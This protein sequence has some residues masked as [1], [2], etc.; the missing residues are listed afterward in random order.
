MTNY[1]EKVNSCLSSNHQTRKMKIISDILGESSGLKLL[2]RHGASLKNLNLLTVLHQQICYVLFGEQEI[3]NR[4]QFY[5]GWY[6]YCGS[7]AEFNNTILA[8]VFQYSLTEQKNQ[9][10]HLLTNHLPHF[11]QNYFRSDFAFCPVCMQTGYHSYFHQF[12]LLQQCPFHL[13]H[14]QHHCPSCKSEIPYVH[15]QK[16]VGPSDF[17]GAFQC[18]RCGYR[19]HGSTKLGFYFKKWEHNDQTLQYKPLE[20][21]ILFNTNN[22]SC[23]RKLYFLDDLNLKDYPHILAHIL[24]A[25]NPYY[26]S[27]YNHSHHSIYSSHTLRTIHPSKK[28]DPTVPWYIRSPDSISKFLFHQS[29]K[30]TWSAIT[31]YARKSLGIKNHHLCMNHYKKMNKPWYQFQEEKICPYIYAYSSWRQYVEGKREHNDVDA[32]ITYNRSTGESC[33]SYMYDRVLNSV[34]C[35]IKEVDPTMSAAGLRWLCNH[36]LSHIFIYQ[37]YRWIKIS[38]EKREINLFSF[39]KLKEVPFFC[40]VITEQ[41]DQPLEFHWLDDKEGFYRTTIGLQCPAKEQP[42][43]VTLSKKYRLKQSQKVLQGRG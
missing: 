10:V 33:F 11:S 6:R 22:Q 40:I 15:G 28:R 16:P 12:E 2:N 38:K 23:S 24:K 36:V 17:D 5:N 13:E 39:E 26:E 30:A 34:W 35:W 20:D 9:L 32:G 27:E 41:K 14:L 42:F 1:R 7:L 31:T 18:D 21:W 8:N 3:K 43:L 37:L 29:T 25:I 4:K 19:F